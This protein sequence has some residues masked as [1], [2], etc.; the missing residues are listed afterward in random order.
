MADGTEKFLRNIMVGD[1]VMTYEDGIR[2]TLDWITGNLSD[3][4]FI[5]EY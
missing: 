5:G 4:E 3:E 2:D 1:N